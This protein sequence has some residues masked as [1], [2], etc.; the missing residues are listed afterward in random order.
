MTL[1][2]PFSIFLKGNLN[3]NNGTLNIKLPF[4][5]MRYNL[6]QISLFDISYE[7]VENLNIL[8]AISTNVLT[9]VCFKDNAEVT[10]N[11]IIGHFQ[12]KG[13]TNEKKCVHLM[14]NFFYINNFNENL[15]LFFR[16]L[17]LFFYKK[18]RFMI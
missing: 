6:W 14:Q 5:E 1:G 8:V 11:P 7:C 16:F 12:F 15:T 18:F 17:R 13:E 4:S 3:T 9:D 2:K 10:Y